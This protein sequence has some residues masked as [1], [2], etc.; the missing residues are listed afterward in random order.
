MGCAH[1]LWS[2]CSVRRLTRRL[3][4]DEPS[5]VEAMLLITGP[6]LG[7]LNS[8]LWARVQNGDCLDRTREHSAGRGRDGPVGSSTRRFAVRVTEPVPLGYVRQALRRPAQKRIDAGNE[9]QHLSVVGSRGPGG[10][11]L[12]GKDQS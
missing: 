8:G 5:R 4:R 12:A 1:W 9:K 2:R 7:Q 10:A 3:P 6:G 11:R